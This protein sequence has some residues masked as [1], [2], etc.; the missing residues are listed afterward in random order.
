MREVIRTGR[1]AVVLLTGEA[2]SGKSALVRAFL[3]GLD[4]SVT[5]AVGGCDDLLAPRGLAPFRDMVAELPELA[6]ALAGGQPDEVFPALLRS[7]G[8]RTSVVAVEDVHWADDVSLDAVRYLARRIEG[9]PAVLVLTYRPEDVG[10]THPLRGV[11]GGLNGPNV[12]RIE[13][14]PLSVGAVARLAGVDH[15]EAAE[16]TG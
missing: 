1:G 3:A 11:L 5:T 13:L 2:G 7:V 10:V 8:A 16:S 6:G 14:A 4:A 15:A 12:R 9:V